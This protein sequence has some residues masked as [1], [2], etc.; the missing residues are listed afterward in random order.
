MAS[1]DLVFL[2]WLY[3][4][5]RVTSNPTLS[6]RPCDALGLGEFQLALDR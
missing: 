3:K 6:Q 4:H 5:A 1:Q 2:T